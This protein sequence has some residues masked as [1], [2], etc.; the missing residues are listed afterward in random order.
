MTRARIAGSRRMSKH[1]MQSAPANVHGL[2]RI[3]SDVTVWNA[4]ITC[5]Q[6]PAR[7]HTDPLA[8]L[9]ADNAS[10]AAV[11]IAATV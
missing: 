7:L 2:R 6:P 10:A 8:N 9:L 5:S 11:L 3:G 4:L 1:K